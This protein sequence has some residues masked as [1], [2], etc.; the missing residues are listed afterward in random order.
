M[1]IYDKFSI[2]DVVSFDVY[3]TAI[4]GSGYKNVKVL[5]ILDADSARGFI[6]PRTMH[7]QVY[8]TLPDG[9]PNHFDDYSYLKV[10]MAN[11]TVTAIGAPWIRSESL[12]V[13][14]STKIRITADNVPP[15]KHAK[16][17]EVLANIGVTSI[18]LEVI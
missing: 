3:P 12:V 9:T 16:V 2:N 7:A 4:L 11:G 15:E 13:V 8:P 6:D 5:A 14:S 1:S 10:K 17:V 18:T